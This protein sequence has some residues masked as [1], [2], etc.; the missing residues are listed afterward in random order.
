MINYLFIFFLH[1][2]LTHQSYC[3]IEPITPNYF[4]GNYLL[5][6]GNDNIT[7]NWL[8]LALKKS[9]TVEVVKLQLPFLF[10][11]EQH[12]KI[13]QFY[14]QYGKK[15]EENK[16]VQQIF[17]QSFLQTNDNDK[18]QKIIAILY[19]NNPDDT[20]IIF[21]AAQIF[22]KNEFYQE[23]LECLERLTTLNTS[24]LNPLI[25]HIAQTSC[26]QLLIKL[27]RVQDACNKL[28]KAILNDPK[29][30]LW[31][32]LLHA[33]SK[34]TDP[35]VIIKH[36]EDI[37]KQISPTQ[38]SLF[39]LADLYHHH[40]NK[41][42][43]DRYFDSALQKSYNQAEQLLML[44]H[45]AILYVND[46]NGQKLKKVISTGLKIK[47]D[48][49]PLLHAATHYYTTHEKN[50]FYANQ[51]ITKALEQDK[52]NSNYL[53][54]HAYVLYKQKEFNKANQLLE[55]LQTKLNNNALL[56][57]RLAQTKHKL[58]NTKYA[59][60][61]ITRAEKHAENDNEKKLIIILRNKW[62]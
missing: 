5:Y 30:Q 46:G 45:R 41:S 7:Q 50:I 60:D 29:Q 59:Q 22:A 58:G 37:N 25:Q 13:Q 43:A 20:K 19:K 10:K 35:N 61:L 53:L 54:M 39:Y 28:K 16:E 33:C 24:D 52:E 27:N 62:Q 47:P 11:T 15:L 44:T 26:I 21:Q 32:S 1:F 4:W 49:A 36:L 34:K 2:L 57:I 12:Q 56:L 8:D 9:P 6:G 38:W 48:Y 3:T 42:F 31:F 23:S 14:K 40:K 18:A 55:Q 17:V 51:L